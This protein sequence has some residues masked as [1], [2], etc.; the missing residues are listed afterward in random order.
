MYDPHKE[1]SS[2]AI[3]IVAVICATYLVYLKAK[4]FCS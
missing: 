1:W 4:G 2:A 3:W